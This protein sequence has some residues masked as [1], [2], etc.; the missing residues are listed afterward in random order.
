MNPE[1]E[2][3]FK[4][5]VACLDADKAWTTELQRRFGNCA[6]D[7]RYTRR[8]E[9]EPESELRRCYENYRDACMVWQL[10]RARADEMAT[11]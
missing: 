4:A 7:A 10:A 5:Y 6:G 3:E 1:I 11:A 8:G 2:A 9:G